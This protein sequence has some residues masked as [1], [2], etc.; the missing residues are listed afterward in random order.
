MLQKLKSQIKKGMEGY[1]KG[2]STGLSKLDSITYGLI[3]ENITLIGADSGAGKSSYT[4]YSTIFKPFQEYL[5]SGRKINIHWLIFSFE[6]SPE[7]LFT[8]LLSMYLYETYHVVI[9]HKEILSLD[10]TLSDEHW[11]LI[12]DATPWLEELESLCTIIDNPVTAKGLYAITKEWTKQFGTYKEIER[13]EDYIKED[14]ISNN[15]DQY[16]IAIVDH[17][18]L[19]ATSVGHTSKQEIDD[20][21]NFMIHFRDKC[22]ISW[23]MVQQL[24]RGFKD[25][26]RRTE[27]GGAYMDIQLNDFS[28]TSG[29]VQAA[30][31][32]LAIFYPFREKLPKYKG[33]DIR[34]LGDRARSISVLK[35]RDGN[36]DKCVG[37]T[38]YGEIHTWIELPLP[39]EINDYE[40]YTNP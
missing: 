20:A 25:M 27:A 1:N 12:E 38:F 13:T 35:N 8:R 36:A 23:Y 16:L 34:Q 2:I 19:F 14:Y 22:K 30:N 7:S 5:A 37:I 3:R 4:T 18:K 6:I 9:P 26:S 40:K 11:K 21:C 39:Q 24:N 29:T 17:V 10:E 33:Y 32:I 28:D 15:P 31:T